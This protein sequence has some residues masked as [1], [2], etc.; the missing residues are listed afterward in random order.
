MS[1]YLIPSFLLKTVLA[2]EPP[3]E[4]WN[5]APYVEQTDVATFQA[6]EPI[7]RNI[8][9][10]AMIAGAITCFIML[11]L[12]GF[13]YMTSGGD[14]KKAQAAA[15]TLTFAVLGLVL[16]IGAWFIMR[17][18]KEFTGVDVTIFDIPGP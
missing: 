16:F 10:I 9:A 2:A 4:D 5:M 11:L 18:I 8:L 6:L 7:F 15:S 1:I 14:P 13:K 17:L 3:L 12:G